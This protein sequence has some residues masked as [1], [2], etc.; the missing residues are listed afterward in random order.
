MD[1]EDKIRAG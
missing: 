1:V